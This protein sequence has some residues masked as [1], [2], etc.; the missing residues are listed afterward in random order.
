MWK[1]ILLIVP[2]LILQGCMDEPTDDGCYDNFQDLTYDSDMLF[3]SCKSLDK[4][5]ELNNVY[6]YRSERDMLV[7]PIY[8]ANKYI[9]QEEADARN[10]NQQEHFEYDK[11]SIELKNDL[12]D[13]SFSVGLF[14]FC[15]VFG[16]AMYGFNNKQERFKAAASASVSLLLIFL[17]GNMLLNS[18]EIKRN[19]GAFA[20]NA[21]NA[22]YRLYAS[23]TL[24][25]S[26]TNEIDLKYSAT[27]EA[28]SDITALYNINMCLSNNRKH[29]LRQYELNGN[30]FNSKSELV[31]AFEEK[32]KI[33]FPKLENGR[34]NIKIYHDSQSDFQTIGLVKFRNCGSL[35]FT[36]KQYNDGFG[37]MLSKM[38]FDK[39]VSE[40]ANNGDLEAGWSVLQ[41]SFEQQF[42]VK[43]DES[44]NHLIQMLIAYLVEYKKSLLIG[45]VEFNSKELSKTNLNNFNHHLENADLFYEK[46]TKAAC[47]KN[48]ALTSQSI[49][50]LER[51]S[52]EGNDYLNQ[53]E[54]V[55]LKNGD[56]TLAQEKPLH[57]ELHET[58]I[59]FE[60]EV[61]QDEAQSL[62]QSEAEKL[63]E[64]YE[65]IAEFYA[66]KIEEIYNVDERIIRI[67]NEGW[68][69]FGKLNRVVATDTAHYKELFKEV[70]NISDFSYQAIYPYY[71]HRDKL[72]N[73]SKDMYTVDFVESFFP[74]KEFKET[75]LLAN[76]VATTMIKSKYNTNLESALE[77]EKTLE[78]SFTQKI[79]DIGNSVSKVSCLTSKTHEECLE[80]LKSYNG[81]QFFDSISRDLLSSGSELYL[82]GIGADISGITV[83]AFADYVLGAKKIAAKKGKK[84]KQ[85]DI[86]T[87]DVGKQ[88]ASWT[89]SGISYVGQMAQ[90]AG[91][92][93]MFLG[94]MMQL[95][96]MFTDF[97]SQYTLIAVTINIQIMEYVIVASL[98]GIAVSI[99][100]PQYQKIVETSVNIMVEPAIMILFSLVKVFVIW[101]FTVMLLWQFPLIV[102]EI[103][104][105]LMSDLPDFLRYMAKILSLAIA[106]PLLFFVCYQGWKKTNVLL[107][108]VEQQ[109]N[110]G[111]LAGGAVESFEL[112]VKGA[113]AKGA[114]GIGKRAE[115]RKNL[116]AKKRLQEMANQKDNAKK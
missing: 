59:E 4:F 51:F 47:A 108:S 18:N 93:T 43:T 25:E 38:N 91:A 75:D 60:I 10:F 70:Q 72:R 76:N 104:N 3:N 90:T 27:P 36:K 30:M 98:L 11:K 26:K 52:G 62:V 95:L 22:F 39:V 71:A 33:I 16:F 54:C 105:T 101:T 34:G 84:G 14:I 78:R 5:S 13:I 111:E 12:F 97:I 49:K 110:I 53:Y 115:I 48:Y 29:E 23:A 103:T 73:G 42:P 31:S 116:E 32:N 56:I 67:L 63:A 17:I 69:S 87:A 37:K 68:S 6:H 80:T 112:V 83:K 107:K 102:T 24:K 50:A 96:L 55:V 82:F 66:S 85:L 28:Y 106:V 94:S 99:S 40:A 21:G 61:L 74:K 58:D 20:N 57:E 92:R 41:T 113:F 1:K 79:S 64:K 100:V 19:A 86:G 35:H 77:N 65:D 9:T 114:L 46:V 109:I 15:V 44:R 88:L 81:T 89:G 2:L 45:A 8:V 7:E